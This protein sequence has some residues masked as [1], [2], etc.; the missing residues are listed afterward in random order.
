[1]EALHP[2]I[3]GPHGG[4]SRA[5]SVIWYDLDDWA[6]TWAYFGRIHGGEG[7]LLGAAVRAR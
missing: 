6:I 4:Y 2:G 1:M 3:F 5:I 7:W